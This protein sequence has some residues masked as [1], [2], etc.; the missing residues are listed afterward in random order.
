MAVIQKST[1]KRMDKEN[2]EHNGILFS[3]KKD[4]VATHAIMWTKLETIILSERSQT[5]KDKYRM[6]LFTW[7]T[8]NR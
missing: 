6:I 7:Y 4:E 1:N 2:A 3:H 5:Q 8:Q